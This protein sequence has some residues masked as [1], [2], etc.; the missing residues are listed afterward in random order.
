MATSVECRPTKRILATIL[1]IVLF[2]AQCY[3]L[4]G[5][6]GQPGAPGAPGAPGIPGFPVPQAAREHPGYSVLQQGVPE[7]YEDGSNA[8]GNMMIRRME[9]PVIKC[10]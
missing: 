5:Q 1:D 8:L 2:V 9:E 6:P 10:M 3:S 4:Q 7:P